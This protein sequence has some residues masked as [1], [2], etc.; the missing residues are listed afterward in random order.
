MPTTSELHDAGPMP[1]FNLQHSADH[2]A[3]R[4]NVSNL[5]IVR[6][7]MQVFQMSKANKKTLENRMLICYQSAV[8]I[9]QVMRGFDKDLLL[10]TFRFNKPYDGEKLWDKF[11][12]LKAEFLNSFNPIVVSL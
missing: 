8:K 3:Y 4:K 9:Y 10:T 1:V 11:S 12:K 7:G 6:T 2:S 5:L